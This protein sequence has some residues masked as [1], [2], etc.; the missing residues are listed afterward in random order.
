M[1]VLWQQGISWLFLERESRT[2]TLT[3]QCGDVEHCAQVAPVATCAAFFR[4]SRPLSRESNCHCRDS[5]EQLSVITGALSPSFD[6]A[7]LT[8]D[9]AVSRSP[10]MSDSSPHAL[11]RTSSARAPRFGYVPNNNSRRWRH[12]ISLA[13]HLRKSISQPSGVA[14]IHRWAVPKLARPEGTGRL[15]ACCSSNRDKSLKGLEHMPDIIISVDETAGRN[16]QS[17]DG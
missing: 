17:L 14:W 9:G 8:V 5:L 12:Q 1:L 10:R 4:T 16:N 7:F 13:P 6:K 11:S 15:V 2:E 3:A